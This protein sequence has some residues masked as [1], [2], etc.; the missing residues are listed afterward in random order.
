M[1]HIPQTN[2]CN[3]WESFKEKYGARLKNK[4]WDEFTKI[5]DSVTREKVA[6]IAKTTLHIHLLQ[7]QKQLCIYCLQQISIGNHTKISHVEHIRPK[8]IFPN[9]RFEFT[10]LA[11]SCNGFNCSVE[12]LGAGK[13]FC[14][15]Y[16]DNKKTSVVYDEKKFL[17]PFE[18]EDIENY[19]SYDFDG[20]VKPNKNIP[21]EQQ[22]KAA[23]M[24]SLVD[25]NNSVLKEFR[26]QSYLSLIE[27]QEVWGE[28]K[29]KSLL[30]N[31]N[32]EYESFQPMLR[33]L[34][35]L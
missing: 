3:T 35:G 11:V 30:D 13:M 9:L 1:R 25:L 32:S 23:Y 33:M 4:T 16:K 8:S 20:N 31:D 28:D 24:I 7:D 14:G 29:I 10:N 21:A 27:T 18:I 12:Q 17:H 26:Q 34:F 6:S 5:T 19:F 22:Q 2:L 15:H